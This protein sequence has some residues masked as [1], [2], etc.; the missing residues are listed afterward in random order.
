M[1]A[2]LPTDDI[3][4]LRDNLTTIARRARYAAIGA[5]VGAAIG[6]VFSRN[7]ASTGGAIGG[8]AGAL[9]ADTQDT[10]SSVI[11]DVRTRKSPDE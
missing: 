5:A 11:D 9:V 10:A 4:A 3:S 1:E 7:A 8:L 2:K 6:A